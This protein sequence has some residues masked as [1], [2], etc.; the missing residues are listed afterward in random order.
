MQKLSVV[1]VLVGLPCA[2]TGQQ[3]DVAPDAPSLRDHAFGV[4]R[5]QDRSPWAGAVVR[6][7]SQPF[8]GCQDRDVIEVAADER[9]R[10]SAQTRKGWIYSAWA[11]SPGDGDW[12]VSKVVDDVV[13]HMPI[14]LDEIA[15]EPRVTVTVRGLGP[16]TSPGPVRLWCAGGL[17]QDRALWSEVQEGSEVELPPMGTR[18]RWVFLTAG[19]GLDLFV[20]RLDENVR[21][22]VDLLV[23]PPLRV[24]IDVLEPDRTP[25]AGARIRVR[26]PAGAFLPGV[27]NENGRL[28]AT[29][30][31]PAAPSD[32]VRPHL[33][34]WAEAP[35]HLTGRLWNHGDHAANPAGPWTIFVQ[36][37][38]PLT[39]LLQ[40]GDGE[41]IAGAPV[42]I[43]GVEQSIQP[44]T[45]GGELVGIPNG[46]FATDGHR[47]TGAHGELP[48]DYD[49]RFAISIGVLMPAVRTQQLSSRLGVEVSPLALIWAGDHSGQREFAARIDRLRPV[50]VQLRH[51]DGSPAQR[52]H[53]RLGAGV[54]PGIGLAYVA[55]NAGRVTILLPVCEDVML[56]AWQ[57]A[58]GEVFKIAVPPG[59]DAT[60][61]DIELSFPEHAVLR[62]TVY[63][64][65]GAPAPGV[66]VRLDHSMRGPHGAWQPTAVTGERSRPHVTAVGYHYP[67][68]ALPMY[69]R[70]VVTDE[71]GEYHFEIPSLVFPLRVGL[72][73]QQGTDLVDVPHDDPRL[74]EVELRVR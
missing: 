18:G 63:D 2:A 20:R 35:G 17:D 25:V 55:D 5:Q 72:Q 34:V 31:T 54:S 28:F 58:E 62:G 32:Q 12:R 1:A 15:R 19:N 51:H 65:D 59:D 39:C 61:C 69:R 53:V 64:R 4:A 49:P 8:P 68:M 50:R 73:G 36:S 74:A 47:V 56:A 7:I 57:G 66:L 6:L 41:P 38:P 26:S 13:P 44:A 14:V 60:V 46:Q 27:T 42:W 3:S 52:A 10:F 24:A 71:R 43:N 22:A 48:L 11:C 23:P 40:W 21:G 16:W 9:G 33:P 30:P 67:A 29:V 45:K 37:S 70:S